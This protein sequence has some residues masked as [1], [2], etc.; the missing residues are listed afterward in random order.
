MWVGF[1][2]TWGTWGTFDN[3]SG[4]LEFFGGGLVRRE[5]VVFGIRDLVSLWCCTIASIIYL[6]KTSKAPLR[7]EPRG[8]LNGN[9]HVYIRPRP[10]FFFFVENLPPPPKIHGPQ[11]SRHL[12]LALPVR[13]R[14]SQHLEHML[15]PSATLLP[16]LHVLQQPL[17]P[18][19]QLPQISLVHLVLFALALVLVRQH[20]DPCRQDANLHLAAARIGT[21]AWCLPFLRPSGIECG[22]GFGP[23]TQVGVR[24]VAAE[25]GDAA[26]DVGPGAVLAGSVGEADDAGNGFTGVGVLVGVLAGLGGFDGRVGEGTV[27]VAVGLGEVAGEGEGGGELGGGDEVVE[28]DLGF[29]EVGGR[30]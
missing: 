29:R 18:M 11:S 1:W 19:Q 15:P 17:P 21:G 20:A 5:R 4:E 27:G 25:S 12:N 10:I 26:L 14:Q 3:M 13:L 30:R 24:V 22:D 7:I 28:G 8:F 16:L 6:Q 23:W 9:I 2:G